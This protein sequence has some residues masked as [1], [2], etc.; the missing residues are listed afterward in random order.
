MPRHHHPHV[1]TPELAA[2][3]KHG[4]LDT[5]LFPRGQ[6]TRALRSNPHVEVQYFYH[7]PTL[8]KPST[9]LPSHEALFW[10]SQNGVG[11]GH[12]FAGAFKSLH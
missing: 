8:F 7:A 10:A 11:I 3:V 2:Q 4:T 5:T 9:G 1:A 6:L 12:Y